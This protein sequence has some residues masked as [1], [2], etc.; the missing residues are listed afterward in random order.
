MTEKD[1]AEA[2]VLYGEANKLNAEADAIR[3]KDRRKWLLLISLLATG[4]ATLPSIIKELTK[5]I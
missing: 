1:K 4:Q 5:L 3:G 2:A